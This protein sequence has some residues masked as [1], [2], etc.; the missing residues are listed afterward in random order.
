MKKTSLYWFKKKNRDNK[1]FWLKKWWC[2]KNLKNKNSY[3]NKNNNKFYKKMKMK[4][5]KGLFNLN[6]NK[7]KSNRKEFKKKKRDK[8]K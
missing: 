4:I 5:S 6:K 7:N 2:M 8:N 1:S 3:L